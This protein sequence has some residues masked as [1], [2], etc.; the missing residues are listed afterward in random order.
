MTSAALQRPSA[1][2]AD[3]CAIPADERFYVGREA[4]VRAEPF[5]ALEIA[6]AD[7]FDDPDE[8]P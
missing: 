8:G 3:F 5:D 7:L 4:T 6:I 1:T 2:Y